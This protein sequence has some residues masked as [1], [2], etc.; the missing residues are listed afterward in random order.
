MT[1]RRSTFRMITSENIFDLYQLTKHNFNKNY[2]KIVI[3]NS[4]YVRSFIGEQSSENFDKILVALIELTTGLIRPT[5][6]RW[7]VITHRQNIVIKLRRRKEA[8]R[9][10]NA[11]AEMYAL[12]GAA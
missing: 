6:N 5:R 2:R 3:I 11:L 4:E 9:L 12:L 7:Q 8:T 10:R 1:G